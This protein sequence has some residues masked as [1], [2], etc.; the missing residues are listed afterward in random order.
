MK[1][2]FRADAQDVIIF[3]IFAIFLLYVVALGVL[4]IPVLLNE[5]HFY[6]LNP[7]PAFGPQYLFTTLL[8]YILFL[9]GIFA[10][11]SSYFFEREEGFGFTTNKKDKG[12]SRWA[13]EKE[14][15]KELKYALTKFQ[16]ELMLKTER[17]LLLYFVLFILKEAIF[18]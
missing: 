1:F 9:G 8:F 11:V 10:T 17:N 15:K 12:Y 18:L 3:I 7:F 5:G 2:K 6:G 13:K 14:M 4:N 16:T